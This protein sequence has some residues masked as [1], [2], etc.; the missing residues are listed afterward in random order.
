MDIKKYKKEQAKATAKEKISDAL[1]AAIY[2]L[3]RPH[4]IKMRLKGL[5]A[6]K[7]LIASKMH[8][9]KYDLDKERSERGYGKRA[10]Y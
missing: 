8:D 6:H 1:G 3:K 7:A 10:K 5:K 2:N 4:D 9:D